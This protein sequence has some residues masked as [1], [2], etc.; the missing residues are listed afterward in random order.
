MSIKVAAFAGIDL[1][2]R[3]AGCANS[4]GIAVGLLVAFDHG[5]WPAI[6]KVIDCA[7]QQGCLAGTGT[8]DKVECKCAGAPQSDA[9]GVGQGVVLRQEIALNADRPRLA[10]AGQTD[11]SSSLA[12]IDSPFGVVAMMVVLVRLQMGM[13]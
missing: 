2:G 3:R 6:P 5:N 9:V 13:I 1:N 8:G 11:A 10:D 12:E 4:L 7:N